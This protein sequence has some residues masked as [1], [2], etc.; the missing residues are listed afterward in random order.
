MAVAEPQKYLFDVATY[1][2]MGETQIFPNNMRIELIEGEIVTMP[3]IGSVHAAVVTTLDDIFHANV[4]E[5]AMI[6][7][8]NPIQ[9]GDLSEPQPDIA[10]VRRDEHHYA[11]AHPTAED[12][13]LLVEVADSSIQYDRET[14]IPLYARY[15]IPEVWI[16]DLNNEYIEIFRNPSPQGYKNIN[17]IEPGE[18]VTPQCLPELH[19][20]IGDLFQYFSNR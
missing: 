1:H 15:A 10:L 16:I 11:E 7:I 5:L 18:W 12:V 14:K 19:I 13:L 2:Q 8:Q 6:R 17:R 3:P 4:G 9:L 20:N